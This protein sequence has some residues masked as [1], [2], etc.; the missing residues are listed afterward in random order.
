MPD[1]QVRVS[2][3]P[4]V[5]ENVVNAGILEITPSKVDE[6]LKFMLG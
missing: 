5:R 6:R 4:F 3:D 2:D 1:L